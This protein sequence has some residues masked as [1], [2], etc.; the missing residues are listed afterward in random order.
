MPT[1]TRGSGLGFPNWFATSDS[2]CLSWT[3]DTPWTFKTNGGCFLKL[4]EPQNAQ[5]VFP[6]YSF[7]KKHTHTHIS[8][9]RVPLRK[10]CT[11]SAVSC[12]IRWKVT[13]VKTWPARPQPPSEGLMS[14][15]SVDMWTYFLDGHPTNQPTISET[16]NSLRAPANEYTTASR[17]K[18]L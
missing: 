2:R 16:P 15:L 6:E 5:C 13:H 11:C 18:D 4:K 17:E 12:S 7:K 9:D 14:I 3:L 1:N 8:F 10:I